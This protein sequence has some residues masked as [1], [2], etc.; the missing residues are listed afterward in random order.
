MLAQCYDGDEADAPEL[1]CDETEEHD[2]VITDE[3]DGHAASNLFQY[4]LEEYVRS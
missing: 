4:S 3:S 1:S 2:S